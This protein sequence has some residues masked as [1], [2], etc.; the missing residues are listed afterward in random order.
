MKIETNGSVMNWAA[1]AAFPVPLPPLAWETRDYHLKSVLRWGDW[2]VMFYRTNLFIHSKRVEALVKRTELFSLVMEHYPDFNLRKTFAYAPHHDDHELIP[3]LGDVCLRTKLMMNA[4]E[5]SEAP[6]A[7]DLGSRRHQSHLCSPGADADDRWVSYPRS[8]PARDFQG[9]QGSP[10]CLCGRQDDGRFLR[11]ASRVARGERCVRGGD[12]Q[13]S[14]PDV[15]QPSGEISSY[16]KDLL[17][18]AKSIRYADMRFSS[19]LRRRSPA[20]PAP[21]FRVIGNPDR[22]TD[23]RTV[24][25]GYHRSLWD[26]SVDS[27]DGVL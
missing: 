13:L 20:S 15:E 22:D 11:G 3:V 26:G 16:R 12:I 8:S 10:V 25:T 7:G 4:E 18:S 21:H 2:P 19:S 14:H 1:R 6:K 9:L 27:P 5:L 24:E 17:R 23:L